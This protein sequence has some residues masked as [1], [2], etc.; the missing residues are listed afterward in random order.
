MDERDDEGRCLNCGCKCEA[1]D[2]ICDVEECLFCQ[3]MECKQ[4]WLEYRS[5]DFRQLWSR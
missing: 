1:K 5:D 2:C 4:P 3:E